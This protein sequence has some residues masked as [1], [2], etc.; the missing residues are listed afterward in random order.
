MRFGNMMLALGLLMAPTLASAQQDP[1]ARIDAAL[2]NAAR[3]EIPVSLIQSKVQEGMA[4]GVPEARIAAA[5]EARLDALV[6][7]R[8]ALDRAGAAAVAAGDLAIAADA[9]QAGVGLSAVVDVMTGTPPERRAVATA[10]LTELVGMGVASDVALARIQSA[11]NAG[12]EALVNLPAEASAN[13]RGGARG[14]NRGN[15]GPPA[16]VDASVRGGVN[17]NPGRPNN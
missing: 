12:G 11:I 4:K 2:A 8:N 7:A 15:A 14:G 5:V 1:S 10:V 13:A 6:R 16:G 3:A 9:I 17:V